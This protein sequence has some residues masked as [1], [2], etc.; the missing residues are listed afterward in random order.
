MSRFQNFRYY[1]QRRFF[2]RRITRIT[3]LNNLNGISNRNLDLNSD[4]PPTYEEAL[5]YPYVSTVSSNVIMNNNTILNLSG[6]IT[7]LDNLNLITQL[8]N[9]RLQSNIICAGNCNCIN[10]I[11]QSITDHNS[12]T[13]HLPESSSATTSTI[14]ASSNLNTS[15]TFTTTIIDERPNS[16]RNFVVETNL[17]TYPTIQQSSRPSNLYNNNES[18]EAEV[19]TI[20]NEPYSNE[21]VLSN[22]NQQQIL[23]VSNLESARNSQLNRSS[24]F[25]DLQSYLKNY[26][27]R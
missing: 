3:N 14:D 13:S 15:S 22:R 27:S 1:L 17:S 4:L 25:S 21:L 7:D 6:S 24:T 8:E 2:R 10:H 9:Q 18:I 16:H 11:R 12:I 26:Q 19:V 5:K 23:N 20:S